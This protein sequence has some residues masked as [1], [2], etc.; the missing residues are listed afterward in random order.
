MAK[1]IDGPIFEL[2]KDRH[3]ILYCQDGPRFVLL[4]AFLKRTQKTPL[5]EIE[6]AHKL[7]KEY[8]LTKGYFELRFPSLD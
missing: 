8:L 5:V 7:Y 1:H 2:R 3:R 4:S 6:Q